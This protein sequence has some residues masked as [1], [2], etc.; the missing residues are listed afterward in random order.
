MTRAIPRSC[1]YGSFKPNCFAAVR[2]GRD[3]RAMP[4]GDE[5]PKK[6]ASLKLNRRKF[7]TA[8]AVAGASGAVNPAR[9]A[10]AVDAQPRLPSPLPPHAHVAAAETGAAPLPSR[11][12][13]TPGSDSMIDVIKTLDIK[14]LPA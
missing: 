4:R 2:A 5:M 10:T 13:G 6:D 14:Y 9:T 12:N 3:N 7:L 8:A 1:H 11:D